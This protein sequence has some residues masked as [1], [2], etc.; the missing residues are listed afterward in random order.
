[1]EEKS[2][3]AHFQYG[4]I[5]VGM[6]GLGYVFANLVPFFDEMLGL[7]GGLLAGP[8]SFLFPIVFFIG[9]YKMRDADESPPEVQSPDANDEES[10]EVAEFAI[11]PR[12]ST[13]FLA[14]ALPE[15]CFLLVALF[16]SSCC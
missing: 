10:F 4:A 11:K 9:A 7:I 2:V 14:A 6:L 1:M 15:F 3:L 13:L 8:I 5:A 12:Q 16:C